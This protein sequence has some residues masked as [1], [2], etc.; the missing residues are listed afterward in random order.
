[1]QLLQ[2]KVH[3]PIRLKGGCFIIS[4]LLHHP[5]NW[6]VDIAGLHCNPEKHSEDVRNNSLKLLNKS[7]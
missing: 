1:M 5:F 3:A 2:A 7:F 6:N 4:A